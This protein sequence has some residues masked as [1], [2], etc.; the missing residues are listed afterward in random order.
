[1]L[2]VPGTP[3]LQ[4]PAVDQFA[5]DAPV[6][7][8][9]A[10]K[11]EKLIIAKAMAVVILKFIFM[12]MLPCLR[13]LVAR[14]NT[15]SKSDIYYS[16]LPKI[17]QGTHLGSSGAGEVLKFE[18]ASLGATPSQGSAKVLKLEAKFPVRSSKSSSSR[19]DQ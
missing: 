19:H 11:A 18:P 2:P 10:A 4:L 6:Q 15:I 16:T 7:T 12:F 8:P 14:F 13:L 9:S 17:V 5:S 1:V 3:P